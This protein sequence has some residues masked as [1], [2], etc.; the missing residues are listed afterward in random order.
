MDIQ[1]NTNKAIA[2]NTLVLYIRLAVTTVCGFLTTRYA[3]QALGIVD[4]GLF[5]VLGSIIS[6]IAILNTIMVSTTNRYIAVSLGNGDEEKANIQFNVCLA[7]HAAIAV[8]TALIAY[9]VGSWYINNVLNYDG[10]IVNASFIYNVTVTASIFSFFSV[11]YSG[12]LTAKENFWTFCFPPIICSIIRLAVAILI[13]YF[14]SN[15]LY[16]FAVATALHSV[17]PPIHYIVYC[18][19]RYKPIVKFNFVKDAKLYKEISAFSGWVAYGAIAFVG[20][21]QG[22]AILVNSFF[23]TVMNT[24]LGVANSINSIVGELSRSASQSI[25]PQITKSYAAGNRER[26]D[27]LLVLSTKITFFVM[28]LVSTPFL[29]ECEWIMR[30]WLGDVPDYAVTFSILLII[31]N[32]VDSLNSGVKSIIFASGKIK[33][34]QIVPSTIKLSSIIAAYFVLRT[35]APAYSLIVVYILFS[36]IVVLSNQF[37]LKKTVDFNNSLLIRQSYFPSLLI[38]LL[39]LPVFLIHFFDNPFVEILT[40][41]LYV[42]LLE[43]YIGVSKVERQALFQFVRS[44]I[45]K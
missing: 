23:S 17:Y 22:A 41:V 12:L 43:L 38:V 45:L 31:D 5:S 16:I 7:F 33:L 42:A 30:L 34:F 32:L 39:S 3:L 9:P 2:K 18:K 27:Y 25:D 4:F 10:D 14:F 29:A 24:A 15:K 1:E 26:S 6:F 37:I 13:T 20:K 44:K 11:P 21:A 36:V 40:S 8:I 28:F 35:G 19:K